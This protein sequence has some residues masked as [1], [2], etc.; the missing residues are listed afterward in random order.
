MLFNTGL[1]K[2]GLKKQIDLRNRDPEAP[3]DMNFVIVEGSCKKLLTAIDYQT[4]IP[5]A[6][7]IQD[8]IEQN[9]QQNYPE[10]TLESFLYAYYGDYMDPFLPIIRKSGDHLETIGLALFKK[11]KYVMKVPSNK[12]FIFKMLFQKFDQGVYDFEFA[13]QKHIALKNVHTNVSYKVKNGNSTSPEIFA[14]VSIN[15]QIRQAYPKSISKNT[16]PKMEKK[17]EKHMAAEAEKFVH[18][19][20]KKQIDPLQLGQHVRS[21][22][23][24]FDG[25]SWYDRYAAAH[26]HCT[27]DTNII[28]TG[29]SD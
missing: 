6:R 26:F 15:A 14:H 2:H 8:M 20:Q 5:I 4:Q 16:G 24:G 7:Y 19:L 12:V 21:Y 9:N 22:T 3:R 13:P 28:Q 29:I 17:I 27:V 25:K 11:D 10:S 18:M 23:R 1:A